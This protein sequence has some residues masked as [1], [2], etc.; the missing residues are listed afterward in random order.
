MLMLCVFAGGPLDLKIIASSVLLR[1]PDYVLK[2]CTSSL[3]SVSDDIDSDD[4]DGCRFS[5]IA[6][7]EMLATKTVDLLLKQTEEL[8]EE[9]AMKQP[10]LIYAASHWPTHIT[11]L[12]D[13]SLWP[14]GLPDKVDR[15]FIEPTIYFNWLRI[16]ERATRLGYQWNISPEDCEPPIYR[17]SELSL[18]RTVD[19]LEN[20]GADPLQSGALRV[21]VRLGHLELVD[22]LLK[23]NLSIPKER[24]RTI[25][26]TMRELG[27]LHDP[28]QSSGKALLG[29][30]DMGLVSFTLPGKIVNEMFDLLF[31]RCKDEIQIPPDLLDPAVFGQMDCDI[32]AD[33]ILRKPAGFNMDG[34]F[35]VLQARSDIRVTE[36]VL[37][38]A[39][40]NFWG[41][42]VL[43][44]LWARMLI[45]AASYTRSSGN[46][47]FLIDEL[48]PV[49]KNSYQ[50]AFEIS[51]KMIELAISTLDEPLE[52]LELFRGN[53]TS[54]VA[55][56]QTMVSAAAIHRKQ[57]SSLIDHLSRMQEHPIPVTENVLIAALQSDPSIAETLIEK[58]P[59]VPITDG[60]F[61]AACSHPPVLSRL[62]DK[63]G[64]CVP[65]DQIVSKFTSDE[66]P[67]DEVLEMLFDRKLLD[68][69]EKL[70]EAMAGRYETLTSVLSQAPDMPISHQVL[71]EAAKDPRSISILLDKRSSAPITEN[72][73]RAA[74]CNGVFDAGAC[75]IWVADVLSAQPQR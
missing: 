39:A 2:I 75:R 70:L 67:P 50:A 5:E 56:T 51:A 57:A 29:W 36:G 43:R 38:S 72:V 61:L 64:D 63:R 58:C 69:D 1:L 27:L 17:A 21:A 37:A 10:V 60:L 62:L 11:A 71:V 25:M 7:H 31:G 8:T 22:L 6:A 45:S 23:K 40:R 13:T 48:G 20:Q 32:I 9:T 52:M 65:I 54:E 19:I 68:V 28:S 16:A 49:I 55:V 33:I 12:G 44:L 18:L 73:V 66:P 34:P 59:E 4:G 15:L 3:L 42:D 46:L 24:L 14:A 35:L 30:R 47:E 74:L 53:S 41:K 26:D